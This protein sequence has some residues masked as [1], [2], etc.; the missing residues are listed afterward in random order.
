MLSAI[1]APRA[2]A[3]LSWGLRRHFR[4]WKAED[5]RVE[6][7]GFRVLGL[8]VWGFGVR[9]VRVGDFGLRFGF[10]MLIDF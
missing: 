9:A 5:M 8:R 4:G 6:G 1:L 3:T 10:R 7:M 2:R